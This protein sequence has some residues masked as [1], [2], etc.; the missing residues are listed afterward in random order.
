MPEVDRLMGLVGNVAMK[1][2][3]RVATT[4]SLGINMAGLA[5]IDGVQTVQGDR[6][7]R[8]NDTDQ[9]LNGIWVA[10]SGIWTRAPDFDGSY[11]AASGTMV[12]V[13][14]GTAGQG[15]YQLATVDPITIGTSNILWTI[16]SGTFLTGIAVVTNVAA[17]KALAP[18]AYS[19][20]L[21]QGYGAQGD[22]GW[23]M[24]WWNA[25]DATADNAG[26]VIQPNAGGVGRWNRL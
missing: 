8:K 26:T 7:L 3:C 13:N 4:A 14:S 22:G 23:G 20:V 6:V 9:T 17:L 16:V 10:D 24:F 21:V 2:P 15:I 1:A 25:A 18:G 12:K 5:V 19:T 11:D